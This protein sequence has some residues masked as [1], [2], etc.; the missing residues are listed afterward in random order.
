MGH[1]GLTP[2]SV[3]ALGGYRV[4][5]R[6]QAAADRLVEDA[7]ALEAAGAC[8]IVLELVP[9]ARR[10]RDHGGAHHPDD[11]HRRGA[12]LR[13]PGARA[14][15][16]AGAQRGVLAQVP[17]ALRRARRR[18]ARRGPRRTPPRCGRGAIRARSTA[19]SEGRRVVAAP[20]MIEL[21]T[22]PDLKGWVRARRREGRRIGAGAHDGLS[23]RGTPR[24]GGRGAPA[25]GRGGHEH[26]RQS[27]AVRAHRGPRPLPP[28]PRRATARSRRRAAS[29]R[30]SS[31]PRR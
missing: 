31:R 11:R 22:I 4:Q 25:G 26:L 23:A 15:R 10:A 6:D 21:T 1:L 12:G 28:R 9:A 3:H 29:T 16:H 24:A 13:R 5:G 30:C 27:A 7:R 8:A 17:Q 2:Q 18:G 14:A 19:S 20:A